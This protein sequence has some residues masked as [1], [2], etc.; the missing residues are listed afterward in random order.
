[1]PR[2]H[3][4]TC[5]MRRWAVLVSPCRVTFA[6]LEHVVV[7]CRTSSRRLC[8]Q[9][10]HSE[11]L[12]HSCCNIHGLQKTQV[13]AIG[14]QKPVFSSPTAPCLAHPHKCLLTHRKDCRSRLHITR[15]HRPR[16]C[17]ISSCQLCLKADFKVQGARTWLYCQMLKPA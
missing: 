10:L 5:N 8:T 16:H 1:M 17:G 9:C 3:L 13:P 12:R 6:V 4:T 7:L 14:Q 15:A 11:A 2:Y